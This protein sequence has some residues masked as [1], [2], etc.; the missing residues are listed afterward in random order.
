[1]F[2]T[3]AVFLGAAV[4]LAPVEANAEEKVQLPA[5]LAT[6]LCITKNLRTAFA[7]YNTDLNGMDIQVDYVSK[8]GRV[9]AYVV[10]VRDRADDAKGALEFTLGY[11]RLS[12]PGCEGLAGKKT[13]EELLNSMDIIYVTKNRTPN[14]RG[15]DLLKWT[16]GK[17]ELL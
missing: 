10:G 3:A 5:G 8:D 2:R 15:K 9:V 4:F 6:T 1:M 7:L 16:N 17:F 14:K 12:V 13:P 11:L